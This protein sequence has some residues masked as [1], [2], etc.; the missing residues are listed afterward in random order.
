MPTRGAASVFRETLQP[1]RATKDWTALSA[2]LLMSAAPGKRQTVV[3][4][5]DRPPRTPDDVDGTKGSSKKGEYRFRH[6]FLPEDGGTRLRL[7]GRIEGGGIVMS[8][9]GKMMLGMFKKAIAKD[10]AALKAH[11]ESRHATAS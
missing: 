6:D 2:A 8:L 7:H 9:L 11:V 4:K 5:L 3:R 10:L 1:G